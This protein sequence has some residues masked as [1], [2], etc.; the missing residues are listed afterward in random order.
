M[1]TKYKKS[2]PLKVSGQLSTIPIANSAVPAPDSGEKVVFNDSTSGNLLEKNSNDETFAIVYSKKNLSATGNQNILAER[3][4][5]ISPSAALT[6][7]PSGFSIGK[8]AMLIII[9]GGTQVSWSGITWV[10]GSAP[11]LLSDGR[12]TICLMSDG[13]NVIASHVIGVENE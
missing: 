4:N 9:N 11:T 8:G 7:T 5:I 12:N 3:I 2:G 13:V 10:G 6:L 1:I